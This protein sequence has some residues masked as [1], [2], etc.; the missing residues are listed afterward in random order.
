MLVLYYPS[1]LLTC[2]GRATF[3]GLSSLF[4][5]ETKFNA[6]IGRCNNYAATFYL[7][8]VGDGCGILK[9]AFVPCNSNSDCSNGFSCHSIESII[10]SLNVTSDNPNNDIIGTIM[11]GNGNHQCKSFSMMYQDLN[12]L[13][14][15]IMGL[16]PASPATAPNNFC[17]YNPD[18]ILSVLN[19][20]R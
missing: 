5:T 4:G 14:T 6:F 20:V 11:F 18:H 9:G 3:T 19:T 16:N 13:A 2:I 12:F 1:Q 7:E 10:G 8:C 17:F 15:R